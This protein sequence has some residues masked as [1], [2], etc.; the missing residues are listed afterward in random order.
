LYGVTTKKI[1]HYLPL[2]QIK[3][4]QGGSSIDEF[5]KTVEKVDFVMFEDEYLE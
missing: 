4:E 5:D 1:L 3:A 2:E